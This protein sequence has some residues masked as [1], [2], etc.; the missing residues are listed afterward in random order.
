MAAT[1]TEIEPAVEARRRER[2]ELLRKNDRRLVRESPK[3]HVAH[4]LALAADCLYNRGMVVSVGD[5]PPG[6]H[7][8]DKAVPVLKLDFHAGRGACHPHGR[9]ILQRGVGMP[10]ERAV[11]F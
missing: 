7:R 5:A 6:R 11:V 9:G 10:D 8:V 2:G 4:L 3:H 1:S